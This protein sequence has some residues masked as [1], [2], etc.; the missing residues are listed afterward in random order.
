MAFDSINGQILNQIKDWLNPFKIEKLVFKEEPYKYYWVSL[1]AEPQLNFLPFLT[2]EREVNG[3]KFQE[4]VYK[5]EFNIQFICC[6]NYGYSEWDSYDEENDYVVNSSNLLN[7]GPFYE[8]RMIHK[9]AYYEADSGDATRSGITYLRPTYL[10]NAG[11][12]AANLN[13]TFDLIL[14]NQNSPLVILVN[15]TPLTSEGWG[16]TTTVSSIDLKYFSNFK[17][18][19]DIF[20]GVLNNWQIEINSNLCEIYLKHK[21]DSSKI[22]SLNRFSSQHTFLTL[23]PAGYVDYTKPFPTEITDEISGTAIEGLYFNQLIVQQAT[24][25][26]RLKN[27]NI[28]WKH[29]YL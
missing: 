4:G 8:D 14:P 26:Y 6:D 15:K 9:S 20:D 3:I 21:I 11:N 23:A 13:L 25:N 12:T 17:P 22:I 2:E 24:E 1:N 16:E 18:F 27:V 19:V 28:E 10:Y 29:T 5:G 7:D